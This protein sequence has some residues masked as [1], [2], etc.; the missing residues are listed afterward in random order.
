MRTGQSDGQNQQHIIRDW[1]QGFLRSDA[2][3]MMR[4]ICVLQRLHE[5][6]RFPEYNY[7]EK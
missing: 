1:N 2:F 6:A 4:R 5:C 3:L 7:P